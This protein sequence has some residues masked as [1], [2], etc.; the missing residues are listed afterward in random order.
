MNSVWTTEARHE[1]EPR[2]LYPDDS[3][4]R[5][6]AP[7]LINLSARPHSQLWVLLDHLP[8]DVEVV[9]LGEEKAFTVDHLKPVRA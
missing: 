8:D 6:T 7:D 2:L 3:S 9:A 4:A 1:C 5:Q